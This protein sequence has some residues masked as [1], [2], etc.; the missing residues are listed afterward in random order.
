MQSITDDYDNQDKLIPVLG[1]KDKITDVKITEDYEH[2]NKTTPEKYNFWG[3]RMCS[4]C[5]PAF[6]RQS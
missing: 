4:V 5:N 1:F 3:Y 2:S 6:T